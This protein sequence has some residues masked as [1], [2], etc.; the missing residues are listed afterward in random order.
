M[1]LILTRHGETEWNLV[2]RTQ[3]RTDTDLTETGREQARRISKRLAGLEFEC[4]YTSPLRRARDTAEIIAQT[5]AVPVIDD[6]SLMEMAFGEWEGLTFTQ[7]GETFPDELS[8]WSSTPH[9]CN[10]PGGEPFAQLVARCAEFLRR[11]E[12]SHKD[13]IIAAVSH[14]VPTKVI[15]ALSLGVPMEKLH[16]IR[17]DNVSLTI[18]DTYGGRSVMRVLNDTSHLP[19]GL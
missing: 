17:I 8:V 5:R 13:G 19:E 15:A 10:I 11:A 18:I 14:S 12:E 3:G 16:N 2:H 1:R 4:V 6:P 7:I 9:F